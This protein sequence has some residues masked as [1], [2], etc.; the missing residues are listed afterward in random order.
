MSSRITR[1]F[2]AGLVRPTI[3]IPREFDRRE[4]DRE[5]LEIILIH[6]LAHADRDDSKFSAAAGLAQCVW[7]FL[8]FP[9]WLR[10]NCAWIRSLW[11]TSGPS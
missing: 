8:P 3:M 10:A 4:F 9:W 11:P 5:L 1:P 2:V 6:E 7:F